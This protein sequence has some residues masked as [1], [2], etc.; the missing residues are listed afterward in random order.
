MAFVD[1]HPRYRRLLARHGLVTADDF[2]GLD[3]VVCC[4]HPDRHV[5]RVALG[6]GAKAVSAFLKREHRTRWRDRLANVWAGF[7]LA[8]RSFREF[9]LLRRLENTEVGG[10]E[11]IAVGEDDNGRAFL[12]L[13]DL[14]GYQDLR[15]F[16]ADMTP[17]TLS[18][19]RDVARQLGAAL[20]RLHNAGFEHA[21]L[22]SKHVLVSPAPAPQFLAFRFLDWQR[23]RKQARVG[24]SKRWRDLAAL[25]A[26]LAEALAN[27]RERLLVL[28]TY[29]KACR[30]PLERRCG[31]TLAAA[32]WEVRRRSLK[33]LGRRRIREM[34]QPA[35]AS[36]TQNLIWVDGEALLVTREFRD[37]L[38]GKVPRWLADLATPGAEKELRP[39]FRAQLLTRWAS[40]PWRWLWAW[41]RRKPL[42]APALES[43]NVLFRL[44]RYGVVMPRLLA[45]GQ[46]QVKPWQTQS[47]LLTEPLSDAV[48]LPQHLAAVPAASR[49]E[50]VR[51]AAR[52]L[53][54]MHQANCYVQQGSHQ[55]MGRLL[56]VC[57]HP[58]DGLTV[59]LATVQG[60][61]KSHYP[62]PLRAQR[63]AAA[64]VGSLTGTC[65]GTDL[66]RGLLA[67][68]GQERLTAAGKRWA[69]KVLAREMASRQRRVA[70]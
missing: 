39:L 58:Q 34:R 17:S 27:A 49:A 28:H 8:S 19:R 46:K 65:S 10:P 55:E 18:K 69:R 6:K 60:I 59:A 15:Q 13:R 51:R 32:A 26:T 62:N 41:L 70:A 48:P 11:A 64:L 1:I 57:W 47:F 4:G 3:G 24:W 31:L 25:D 29:L 5:L 38:G 42:V 7:G 30:A 61:A 35:L 33:L 54:Q 36:G 16:L 20:A 52:V 43:M 40:R 22:Y 50:V 37:A 14:E 23:A 66:M 45:A 21:D 68:L 2:L 44:Q 9:T 67:Y 56:T 53:R 12:L 63:D